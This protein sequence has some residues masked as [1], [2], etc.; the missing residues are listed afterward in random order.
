MKFTKLKKLNI[1]DVCFVSVFTAIIAVCAQIII[2]MPIGVPL[3]LQ[4]FAI[5]L[6]GMIL[7]AKR[8]TLAVFVYILLGIIGV[9]VFAGFK[10]GFGV[11]FGVTGGYIIS[12]P[13]MALLAG[14]S[15]DLCYKYNSKIVRNV[16]AENAVLATGLILGSAIN[17]MFGMIVGKAVVSCGWETAFATFVVPYI[18]T[19]VVKIILAGGIG[20]SVRKIL[21]KNR[22][23]T[24]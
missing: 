18:P 5:P 19:A 21:T 1:R 17:Y 16:W 11:L 9:P 12:F 2:P 3:T 22:I 15:A 23:L 8:G 10:G 6:A 14:I 4:T 24:Q 13:F 7:G 20:V